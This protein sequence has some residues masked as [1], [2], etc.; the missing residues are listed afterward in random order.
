MKKIL[1]LLV[2][3]LMFVGCVTDGVYDK[4]KTLFIAGK[5]VVIQ[6]WD[7]LPHSMQEQLKAVDETANIYDSAR[8]V[9]R[10]AID[11]VIKKKNHVDG[12]STLTEEHFLN[13]NA[14]SNQ[15]QKENK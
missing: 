7:G 8:E 9:V 6:N 12:N 4:A 14:D 13:L 2:V 10:P 11:E 15:T 5:K 1:M 3:G